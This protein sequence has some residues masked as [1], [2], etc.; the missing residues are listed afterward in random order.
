MRPRSSPISSAITNSAISF[1]VKVI[2]ASFPAH[3]TTGTKQGCGSAPSKGLAGKKVQ[4]GL[5][6]KPGRFYLRHSN[7]PVAQL[8]RASDYESEGRTFE[9][10]RVRHFPQSRFHVLDRKSTRLHSSH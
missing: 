2:S 5:A 3:R 7:A 10:F 8:D 4:K 6:Q 1:G 9:S